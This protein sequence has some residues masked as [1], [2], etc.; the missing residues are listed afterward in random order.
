M[1]W[2][3]SVSGPRL[4]P[5]SFSR[6]SGW[7]YSQGLYIG[8]TWITWGSS[9]VW[10]LKL[11]SYWGHVVIFISFTLTIT[12]RWTFMTRGWSWRSVNN[13]TILR[14]LITVEGQG[15]NR[16]DRQTQYIW[17][18]SFASFQ[19]PTDVVGLVGRVAQ[20]INIFT[21][22]FSTPILNDLRGM[23]WDPY[24]FEPI[25]SFYSKR[26]AWIQGFNAKVGL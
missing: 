20:N 8:S 23:W 15:S 17:R 25:L 21:N 24:K 14:G 6:H 3:W 2:G 13:E 7:W 10:N 18:S 16:R 5:S 1:A 4:T 22:I 9:P 19:F 11:A 12:R 26:P